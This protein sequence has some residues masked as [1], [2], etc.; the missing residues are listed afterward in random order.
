MI[1]LKEL[2]NSINELAQNLLFL[3]AEYVYETE[4]ALLVYVYEK[5]RRS[6]HD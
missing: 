6:L 4:D 5:K 2:R 3:E 1:T